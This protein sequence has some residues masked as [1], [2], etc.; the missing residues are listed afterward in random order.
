MTAQLTEQQ[1]AL[2]LEAQTSYTRALVFI[3]EAQST[4]KFFNS[5]GTL[6]Q[7]PPMNWDELSR[8]FAQAQQAEAGYESLI[9][10]LAAQGIDRLTALSA[11]KKDPETAVDLAYAEFQRA[12]ANLLAL[13]RPKASKALRNH[14]RSVAGL[15]HD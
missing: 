10:S 7:L 8:L 15:S 4:F 13:V 1:L 11:K 6:G 14:A 12:H 5:Y 2:C 3:D 9:A